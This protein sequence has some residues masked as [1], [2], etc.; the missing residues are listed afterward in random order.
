MSI[1]AEIQRIDNNIANAL[2]ACAEKGVT[3]PADANSNNLPGLI[4]QISTGVELPELTSP[5]AASEIFEGKQAIDQEGNIQ[6]G[7]FTIESELTDQ[8]NLLDELESV[9]EGK[10]STP[11]LPSVEQATPTITVSSGGLITA[12]ATQEAGAVPA[13]TKSATKQL[14]TQ[15]AKTVTPGTSQQTAVE[16]GRYTTGAVVVAGDS[17]LVPENIVSG[18]TIFG[19]TGTAET[20]G[21][22]SVETASVTFRNV[23]P[24]PATFE[25]WVVNG[26]I[27]AEMITAFGTYTVLKNSFIYFASGNVMGPGNGVTWTETNKVF[28]VSG[29]G[30]INIDA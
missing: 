30:Y 16:S 5:A 1:M 20:G 9:L 27:E 21:G 7:T 22:A 13:G 3:V 12:S 2:S 26:D 19:V 23:S 8:E 10:A 6:M 25:A 4:A 17:N 29:D 15:A 14:T 24:F 11:A 28:L 18:K